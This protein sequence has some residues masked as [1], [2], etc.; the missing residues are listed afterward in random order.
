MTK[1]DY[2]IINEDIEK[3]AEHLKLILAA[4]KFKIQRV[5]DDIGKEKFFQEVN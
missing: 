3:S 2:L 4:E 1:F 5:M